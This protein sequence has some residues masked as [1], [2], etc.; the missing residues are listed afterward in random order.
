MER[1]R[2]LPSIKHVTLAERRS[3]GRS[4]HSSRIFLIVSGEPSLYPRFRGYPLHLD[5][6]GVFLGLSEV[7]L[8]LHAEPNLRAATKSLGKP[9]GHLWGNGG[10]LVH[11]VVKGLARHSQ[12]LG[13]F[14]Y[15]QS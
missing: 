15:S 8:H 3:F 5:P 12:T 1:S 7:I 6:A 14:F 2:F 11:N 10:S 13:R 4:V 9:Y